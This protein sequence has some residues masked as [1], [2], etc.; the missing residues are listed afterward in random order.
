MK[1]FNIVSENRKFCAENGSYHLSL[2][3]S[4]KIDI[5]V[6]ETY[7]NHSGIKNMVTSQ[8]D[9]IA[10]K[11]KFLVSF[12]RNGKCSIT[13]CNDVNMAQKTIVD[14]LSGFEE[15]TNGKR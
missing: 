14:I 8:N 10:R 3:T 11:N 4:S 9:I 2:Q 1:Y 15:Y 7:L 12:E 13:R 6:M 5:L